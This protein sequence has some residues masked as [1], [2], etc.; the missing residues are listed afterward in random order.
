MRALFAVAILVL[1]CTGNASS[2]DA[3]RTHR[4]ISTITT[5]LGSRESDTALVSRD[6]LG[7]KSV[8]HLERMFIEK[9]EFL[10]KS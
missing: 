7:P 6:R 8:Q 1:L 5:L 4:S 9:R 10:L 2:G 3:S